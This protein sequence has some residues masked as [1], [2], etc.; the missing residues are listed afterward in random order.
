[1][2]EALKG[3]G[4]PNHERFFRMCTTACI[5]RAVSDEEIAMTP[6]WWRESGATHLAG[7]PVLVYRQRGVSSSLTIA[8]CDAP[9]FE[10]GKIFKTPVGCGQCPSCKARTKR[11]KELAIVRI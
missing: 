5:Q 10:I 1:M 4:M 6:N 2:T 7:P 9:T 3:V 11:E 8:P